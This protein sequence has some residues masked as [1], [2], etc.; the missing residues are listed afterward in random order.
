MRPRRSRLAMLAV[1]RVGRLLACAGRTPR[2]SARTSG[3]PCR[4]AI[5]TTTCSPLP[6]V[7]LTNGTRP[8]SRRAR[9]ARGRRSTTS[10][11]GRPSPGSRSK[12]IR[13]GRS[14]S[15]TRQPQ[16]WNSITPNCASASS[17]RA[18]STS[19]SPPASSAL[20][21]QRMRDRRRHA[22]DG[23]ALEEAVLGLAGRAAHQR[24]RPADQPGSIQSPTRA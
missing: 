12:T 2:R 22:G 3:Q 8:S 23:V 21:A 4:R 5:G 13:S 24:H 15:S 14:G 16:V 17:P 19:G 7:V 10:R 6:P 1:K 11:Q 20:L 18:S 9:R